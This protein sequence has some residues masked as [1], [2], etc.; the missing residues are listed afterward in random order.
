[1]TYDQWKSTEPDDLEPR[2][3]EEGDEMPS[4]AATRA[5]AI[6]YK[7]LCDSCHDTGLIVLEA[8]DKDPQRETD[9]PCPECP[10]CPDNEVDWR[11]H[12]M[13]QLPLMHTTPTTS[14]LHACKQLDHMIKYL[15]HSSLLLFLCT[16]G[17]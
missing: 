14:V 13:Q 7:E 15:G 3:I 2:P 9:M 16:L 1:M 12:W 6:A 8:W 10:I 11:E 4:H 5:R 17:E